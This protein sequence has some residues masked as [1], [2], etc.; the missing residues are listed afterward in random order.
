MTALAD[1]LAS[2]AVAIL[3][4]WAAREDLKGT[5]R[6]SLALEAAQ[7]AQ[8]ALQW[9]ITALGKPDHGGTLRVQPGAKPVALPGDDAPPPS[10]PH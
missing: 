3:Q 9:K 10:P 8:A 1:I 4:W 7:K 6:A 2:L 5:V